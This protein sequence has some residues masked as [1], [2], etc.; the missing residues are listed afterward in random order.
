MEIRR[1]KRG[2]GIWPYLLLAPA[3]LI[4]LSVVIIPIINAVSMSFQSYNLTRPKKIGFI[5]FQNYEKI[6]QSSQF[7]S[8]LGRTGVWVLWGVGLQFVFGFA[9]ALLLNKNFRGRG[10]VRSVSLIPWVTP[11]VLIAL[12]WRWILDGNYGVLNDILKN[13][14]IITDNIA[15]LASKQFAMPSVI[16]TIVWQ[17]IPFFALMILAGLQSIPEELYEAAN[18]DGASGLQKLF[19]VTIPSLKNT[20]FVTTMLRIIWVANSV[21]VIYNMTEGGPAFATQTLS[22]YIYKEAS[23]LNMGYASAMAILLMLVLMV[24]AIPYLRTTFSNQEA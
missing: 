10:V 13:L 7:W 16:M 6:L 21:D 5:A 1:K 2:A 24:V 20:I 15:F 8:S 14:G 11:G 9:L 18:I 12:M 17:G 4:M 19:Y 22:V 23:I 3:L